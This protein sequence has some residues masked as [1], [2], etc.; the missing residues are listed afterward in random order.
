LTTLTEVAL[1]DTYGINP[2]IVAGMIGSLPHLQK[3]AEQVLGH[4]QRN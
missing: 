3:K 1:V 2:E 4:S